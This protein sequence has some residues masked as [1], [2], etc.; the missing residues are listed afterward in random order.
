MK[1]P[2]SMWWAP[3][4]NGSGPLWWLRA[5]LSYGIKTVGF[6]RRSEGGIG[7]GGPAYGGGM[8]ERQ[9]WK[10]PEDDVPRSAQ[11][12]RPIVYL[13]LA[14]A[15]RAVSAE[16]TYELMLEALSRELA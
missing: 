15:Q 11:R 6:V 16:A 8:L 4:S 13:T 12:A 3:D 14:E 5:R 1:S 10:S 7:L 9:Y 2:Y